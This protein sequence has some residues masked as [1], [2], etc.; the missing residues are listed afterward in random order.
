MLGRLGSEA[1][2]AVD[3]FLRLALDHEQRRGALAQPV[4]QRGGGRDI[5]VRRDMEATRRGSRHDGPRRQGPRSA[6]GVLAETC[7]VPRNDARILSLGSDM[8]RSLPVWS[9]SKG[10]DPPAVTQARTAEADRIRGEYNRLLY[11]AMTRCQGPAGHRRV[12]DAAR[13]RRL[14][15]VRHVQSPARAAQPYGA[16]GGRPWRC[17]SVHR[18][19]PFLPA[20]GAP[21]ARGRQ[22]PR[23]AAG[24]ARTGRWR[25]SQTR[26]RR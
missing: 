13:A 12:R 19:G 25:R 23:G 7:T 14:M 16:G 1:G 9:R 5:T 3:E 24:L 26:R 4:P 11:V 8:G 17:P 21:R 18:S 2:D 15:L 10:S 22:D 20:A 6:R